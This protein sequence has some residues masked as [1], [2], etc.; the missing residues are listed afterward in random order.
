VIRLLILGLTL[1]SVASGQFSGLG[2]TAD[3]S[4][5]YFSTPLRFRDSNSPFNYK[6]LRQDTQL[7][8][9]LSRDAGGPIGRTTA[10]FYDLVAAQPSSDGALVAISATRACIG[11]SGCLGVQ[12]AQSTIVDRSGNALFSDDGYVSMS[13]NGRWALF[14]AR[15][16]FGNPLP[17]ADLVDLSSGK[18]VATIPSPYGINGG[19]RRQVANDGTVAMIYGSQLLLW[20]P[21][22]V[23]TPLAGAT[24]LST[25]YPNNPQLL[26]SA[27]GGKLVYKTAAG[28]AQYDRATNTETALTNAAATWIAMSDDAATIAFVNSAD[29]QVW[30]A[31]PLRQL[32]KE[33]D[34]ILE[35]T[36]SGNGRVAFAATGGGRL[37]RIDVA[38]ATV[39]ELIPRTPWITNY[40]SPLAL[41]SLYQFTGHNLAPA[42]IR[43]GGLD[44]P[45]VS[46]TSDQV[47]FQVP[48]EASLDDA[49]PFELLSGNSPLESPPTTVST[50]AVWPGSFGNVLTF[51]L[52]AAHQDFSGLVAESSPAAAGEV[53]SLYLNGLGPVSPPVAT[54]APGPVPPAVITNPLRC[55]FWDGGPND[56][57][58]YFAGLAPGTLGVYQVNVQVPVGLRMTPV[59][60]TCDFGA[61]TP[62]VSGLLPVS[63]N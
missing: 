20:S 44:A 63:Y 13:P 52:L 53:V 28:L 25:T 62:S 34:P 36:L 4:T 41:G 27:D 24:P 29:S 54:G 55:Q 17:S 15:N 19:A 47:W 22:G 8:Q 60:V 59:L 7:T 32:T 6:T 2:A 12:T 42:R 9:F 39:T 43:I 14:Y 48:W 61:G 23:Q 31:S 57:Q 30:L 5:L 16:L 10:N 33:A 35:V 51:M 3:G 45:V 38:T 56:S 21:S 58:I 1:V 26:I 49:V 18:V 46:S 40:E 50:R 11:G 37:L